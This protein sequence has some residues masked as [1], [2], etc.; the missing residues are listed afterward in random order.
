M[1]TE[2]NDIE[3]ARTRP[4]REREQWQ[5]L[6]EDAKK[7]VDYL[8]AA[9]HTIRDFV[10]NIADTQ[11][12]RIKVEEVLSTIRFF[13]F[14]AI[15]RF[16]VVHTLEEA[17]NTYANLFFMVK[18][19]IPENMFVS[20]AAKLKWI[21]EQH[22]GRIWKELIQY[23][24]KLHVSRIVFSDLY[25]FFYEIVHYLLR[26]RFLPVEE[27]EKTLVSFQESAARVIEEHE[28]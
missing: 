23:G 14:Q 25:P 4:E 16:Q 1:S 26:L 6:L 21:T 17:I 7:Q 3:E 28:G 9:P 13:T 11:E 24:K 5:Q 12:L 8:E 2:A 10:Q 19:L 20:H 22:Y 18:D 15:H 27:A